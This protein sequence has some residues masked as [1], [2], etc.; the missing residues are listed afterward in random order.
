MTQPIIILL[1]IIVAN[2][3]WLS[4]RLFY[5]IPLKSGHKSI[6]WCLFELILL[7]FL[8][9]IIVHFAEVSV[10]GQAASQDWEFYAVTA[11]LFLV[12]AFPGFVYKILWK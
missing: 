12:F 1:A 5:S 3:P 4:N 11:C 9:G 2:L 6:A 10:M 8:M 7:Y